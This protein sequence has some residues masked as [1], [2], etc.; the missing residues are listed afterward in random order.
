MCPLCHQPRQSRCPNLHPGSHRFGSYLHAGCLDLSLARIETLMAGSSQ[1]PSRRANTI[2][3][4]G[5]CVHAHILL[6][7]HAIQCTATI[8]YACIG[9]SWPPCRL[10]GV[11]VPD[12]L[13]TLSIAVARR[14]L[15]FRARG[16][17]IPFFTLATDGI[18]IK[19]SVQV[20]VGRLQF[21]GVSGGA[22]TAEKLRSMSS[23]QVA[24]KSN[25]LQ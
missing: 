13:R 19:P 10:D 5:R 25:D 24:S 17:C 3:S 6:K 14:A 21:I 16:V 23:S 11:V 18:Q 12:K 7:A 4:H 22:I 9:D 8:T 2:Q 1:S 15:G 20:D